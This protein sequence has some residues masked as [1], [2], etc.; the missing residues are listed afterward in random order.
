[1]HRFKQIHSNNTY[2]RIEI[3]IN[4]KMCNIYRLCR[5]RNRNPNYSNV[6]DNS[7]QSL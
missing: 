5:L 2:F 4:D 1:M 6:A 7:I 3:N